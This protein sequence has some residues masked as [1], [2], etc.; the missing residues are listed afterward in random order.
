MYLVTKR[1][2]GRDIFYWQ[3]KA[4]Y[5]VNGVLTDCPF[6]SRRLPDDKMQ[7]AIEAEKYTTQLRKW[8][9]GE[10]AAIIINGSVAWL[11]GQY[12]R[13]VRFKTLRNSTQKLYLHLL[14][15]ISDIMGDQK[16]EAISR[17]AAREFC[18][19]FS[20]NPRKPSM[21]AAMGRVIFNYAR[22]IGYN[23]PNPFEELR[24]SKPKARTAIWTKG[25]IEAV[26]DVAPPSI[27]LA[28]QL[29]LDTGQRPG[30]LRLLAWNN[31]NGTHIKLRQSKT[32][33]WVDIP[34]MQGLKTMLDGIPKEDRNLT[35]LVDETTGKTY[36]RDRLC[37]RFR[38]YCDKAGIDKSIQ[39]RDLRRS[40]VVRLAEHG[41]TNAEI[42]AISGHSIN[43]T[44]KILEVY[45]P[46]SVTM[47]N[48]AIAKLEVSNS[49]VGKTVGSEEA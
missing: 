21:L 40:C 4:K 43:E 2:N 23:V 33:V 37:H 35:I 7:A 18:M 17:K 27:S 10:E 39:F 25:M 44:A 14:P 38:E 28:L 12:K 36:T 16:I 48:N 41:C 46:R 13:D 3:P 31:Y 32:G 49:T 47:A 45:L 15:Q 30:D 34:V 24:I 9:K 1:V 42:A 19:A 5:V 11:I 22:D 29:G 20:D 8:R 6:A 26:H